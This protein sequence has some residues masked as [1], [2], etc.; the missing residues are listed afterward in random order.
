[1]QCVVKCLAKV[2]AE[3]SFIVDR[4]LCRDFRFIFGREF[5]A[6]LIAAMHTR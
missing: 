4:K 2:D 6:E 1:M 3:L 5:E